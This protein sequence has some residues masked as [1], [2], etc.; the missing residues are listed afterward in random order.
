MLF[1]IPHPA[2]ISATTST[3]SHAARS[4]SANRTADDN[5]SLR[6]TSGDGDDLTCIS[7]LGLAGSTG[8]IYVR[9]RT[10]GANLTVDPTAIFRGQEGHDASDIVRSRTALQRTVLSHHV[11][12]LVRGPIRSRA[13]DVVPCGKVS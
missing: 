8:G 6:R 5:F 7:I 3:T 10:P 12:D 11:L 13:G 4:F 2:I 1:P 9:G